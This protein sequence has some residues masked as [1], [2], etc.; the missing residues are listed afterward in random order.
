MKIASIILSSLTILMGLSQL[1]CGLWLQSNGADASNI[2]FHTRLGIGTVVMTLI[3]I[4]V[5]LIFISKR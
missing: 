5:M 3:T 4:V 2:A 1:I